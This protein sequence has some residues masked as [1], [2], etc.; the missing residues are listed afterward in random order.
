MRRAVSLALLGAIALAAL[1]GCSSL[2]RATDVAAG[3]VSHQLC[4]ATYVTKVEPEQFYREAI[5]PIL[6]PVGFLSSHQVDRGRGE[7]AASFAGLATT[8]AISR[9][10]LG[11]I[12]LHGEPPASVFMP[13]PTP[14][15][16]LLPDIAG[17]EIVE[18][19][20]PALRQALDRVFTENASPPY[21]NTKAVV[22]VRDG[23]VIA[24]RYALG[25]GVD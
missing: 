22:V 1:L 3:Y 8:R 7:V 15:P 25:Y 5:A 9:G 6:S 16:A 18:P 19:A 10:D 13:A 17:P 11:C 4:S 23:R 14:A 21:R 2:D 20:H 12:V 24:E